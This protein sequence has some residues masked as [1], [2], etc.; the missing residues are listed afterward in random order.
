MPCPFPGPRRASCPNIADRACAYG[1]PGE[2]VDGMD[3]LAVRGA[4]AHAVERARRGEGPTLIEAKTY[5]WYGHSHSDPRAY[6][7]KDEEA[8]WKQRDPI[9][10]LKDDLE[11]V[12]L[13]REPEYD[14]LDE[15]VQEKLDKAMAFSE[16][17]P[18]P[19]PT[20]IGNRRLCALE[21]H[22]RRHRG[23]AR[24]ARAR[25]QR[26]QHAAD[27]LLA[28]ADRGDARRD[29]ARLGRVHSWAR[30]W[31]CTAARMARRAACGRNSA[32][33]ACSIRRSPR[34]RSAARRSA[35]RWP[36]CAR[37]RDHVRRLHSAGDGS[38]RQSGREEP[39]H[40]RRQDHGADGHSHRRRRRPRALPRIT[41]KASNRCGRTSPGST[42]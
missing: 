23:R 20:R 26:S 41:R 11:A 8:A 30:T 27:R 39:L 24:S 19:D 13:L 15:A 31:A 16:A 9:R 2:V 32:N 38:N 36:G 1:I 28:S 14:Q 42:S 3:A 12:G 4:V 35:R 40:V 34:P 37:G 22:G 21:V 17:S 18:E 33:G 7:T 6:R 25:A 10:V 5:R 29:A